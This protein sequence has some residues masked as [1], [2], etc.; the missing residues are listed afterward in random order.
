MGPFSFNV[1]END[2]YIAERKQNVRIYNYAD[3]NTVC[4]KGVDTFMVEQEMRQSIVEIIHWFEINFIKVNPD[5]F[6]TMT[7]ERNVSDVDKRDIDYFVNG[8][9][10]K[11]E[12]MITRIVVHIDNKLNFKHH[13]SEMTKKTAKQINVLARQTKTINQKGKLMMYNSYIASNFS[14][15]PIIW[16]FCSTTDA[17]KLEKLQ[18]RALR[19]IFND[20]T[21]SYV[22]LCQNSFKCSLYIERQKQILAQTFK[23]VTKTNPPYMNDLFVSK[24]TNYNL[25]SATSMELPNF[26]TVTYGQHTFRYEGAKLWNLLNVKQITTFKEFRNVLKEWSGEKCTCGF[27]LSCKIKLM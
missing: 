5:K 17:Q 15:C 6:Q 1:F 12:T 8:Q 2:L 7:L 14:Y 13:I 3:D 21:S 22:Q 20:S 11:T 19:L 9:Q 23:C 24:V 16:H 27:C 26:K 18:E 4:C 10:L 25:R